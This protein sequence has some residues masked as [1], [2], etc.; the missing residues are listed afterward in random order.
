MPKLT[1]RQRRYIARERQKGTPVT[2]IAASMKVSPRHVRR[3]YKA[4]QDAGCDMDATRLKRPGR[5]AKQPSAGTVAEVLGACEAGGIG[6]VQT[7]R[8]LRTACRDISYNTVYRIMKG[9]GLVVPSRA[10]SKRR[11]WVRYE[12]RYSNA[13]WH[14]DYHTMKDPRLKG[15]HLVAYLDDASRCITGFGVFDAATSENAAKVLIRAMENFGT[16]ATILSDNG[17]QF[18]S[19]RRTRD[20]GAMGTCRLTLFE[21]ALHEAGIALINSRPYHPQTNGKIERFFG[22]LEARLPHFEGLAAFMDDYNERHLHMSLDLEDGSMRTPREAFG[23]KAA[24]EAIR[25]NNPKWMEVDAN[26]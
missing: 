4:F 2:E 1:D 21:S 19:S 20:R 18:T 24:T 8:R 10:K 5:P 26:D 12:R 13:M 3:I 6:V 9:R 11:R 25:K 17:S 22:T 16:P 14:V 23:E 15:L 7:A